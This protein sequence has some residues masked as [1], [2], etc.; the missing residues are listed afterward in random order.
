MITTT[1]KSSEQGLK[2]GN[3]AI[4]GVAV[5]TVLLGVL[6]IWNIHLIKSEAL[7]R[8]YIYAKVGFDKDIIYRRWASNHGGVYVK[9]DSLTPPNPYLSHIPDRDIRVDSLLTLTLINPAYMTRQVY[10]LESASSDIR[11]HITSL[12][13]IRPE[14]APDPWEQ[15]VLKKF[16]TGVQEVVEIDSIQGKAYLRLMRPFITESS[17]LKCHAHQGYKVNDIRGG[18]S[19]SY[20]LGNLYILVKKDIRNQYMMYGILWFLGALGIV[21]SYI[22]LRKSDVKRILAEVS[23]R[24]LNIELEKKVEERSRE[25]Q[26]SQRDWENIFDSLGAPAQL[27]D[28]N[29][30]IKYVNNATLS[31]F[32]LKR[33]DVI[34]KK[35]FSL[36]NGLSAPVSSCP[37]Q[38]ALKEGETLS[39]EIFLKVAEKPFIISCSPIYDEK[40]G[41]ES[42]MHIM[43]DISEQKNIEKKLKESENKLDKIFESVPI[44]VMLTDEN[45][46]IQECNSGLLKLHGYSKKEE[47]IGKEY[48]MLL[49][50]IERERANAD[51]IQLLSSGKV[52]SRQYKLKQK[53]NTLVDSELS[54]SAFYD[55]SQKKNFVVVTASDI[56]ARIEVEKELAAYRTQLENLVKERTS[57]LENKNKLLE[58]MNKLFVGRELRMKELKDQI[59]R[60]KAAENKK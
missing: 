43:T 14:N 56:T 31:Q 38:G 30:T 19:I 3:Y 46:I 51:F 13:P 10:E 59:E 41:I 12:K 15:K 45:G 4:V 5:W 40:G 16:E 24:Q 17:C 7:N 21:I 6:L 9:V 2:F 53:D 60:L 22:K 37:L 36:F 18:I 58:Q 35:C 8:A 28:T 1:E 42:F 20:P 55:D 33:E 57:E 39:D 32:Q 11:G 47:L 34:G 44:S 52:L 49:P 48:S 26:K 23:L 54:A 50:N 29:H 25:L 27:I